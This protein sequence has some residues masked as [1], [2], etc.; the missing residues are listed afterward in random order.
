MEKKIILFLVLITVIGAISWQI[1]QSKTKEL[2]PAENNNQQIDTPVDAPSLKIE[3][4]KEGTG[5][6]AKNGDIVA[7]HYTG[8]LEDGTKFDSSLDRG[9]PFTFTLGVGQVIQG[10]DLG[11]L[12]M[13]AGEKRKLNIPPELGY[14]SQ[15]AGGVIPPNAT[16][17]FEVEL[18]EINQ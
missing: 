14:G 6:E 2:P 8:W 12:G 11:V 16:L 5:A 3:T 18:L 17:I 1:Y 4:L 13:K 9:T 15:G 10:W 7:V